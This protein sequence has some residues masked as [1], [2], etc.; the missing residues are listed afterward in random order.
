VVHTH[1]GVLFTIRKNE[2]M[3][4]AGKWMELEIST[5]SEISR[6]EKDRHYAFSLICG[7]KPLNMNDR[8]VKQVLFRGE[9]KREAGRTQERVE[10]N[11]TEVFYTH[12]RK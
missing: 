11:M 1:N 9:Y 6:T 3:S 10:V 4:L 5:L 7:I 12:V 2:I 8:S